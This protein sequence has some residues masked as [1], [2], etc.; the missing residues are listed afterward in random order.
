MGH[1]QVAFTRE[2]PRVFSVTSDVYYRH[3]RKTIEYEGNCKK[4]VMKR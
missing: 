2:V 4:E 3:V 1:F